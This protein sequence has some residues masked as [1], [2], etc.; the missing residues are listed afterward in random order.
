MVEFLLTRGADVH[1]GGMLWATPLAWA[2][3][4]GHDTVADRLRAAGART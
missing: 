1:R 4:K 2:L 3:K